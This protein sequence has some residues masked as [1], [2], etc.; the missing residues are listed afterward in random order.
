M[1]SVIEAQI[2]FMEK[3]AQ[4]FEHLP[5][6]GEDRAHWANV[7]NAANARSVKATLQRMLNG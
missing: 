5:T 6:E 3:V 2:I 4:H 1:H 7:Y